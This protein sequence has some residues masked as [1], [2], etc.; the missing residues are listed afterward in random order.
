MKE[1]HR[2]R[3]AIYGAASFLV[4]AWVAVRYCGMTPPW[5]TPPPQPAASLAEIPVTRIASAA[6]FHITEPHG[7]FRFNVTLT[8]IPAPPQ[9]W[10]NP[11]WRALLRV[12]SSGRFP[13]RVWRLRNGRLELIQTERVRAVGA[14]NHAFSVGTQFQP[15]D[16][17]AVEYVPALVFESSWPVQS[18]I[19]NRSGDP[20]SI[21]PHHGRVTP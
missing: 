11:D 1:R 20:T 2:L 7:P 14:I 6:I 17:I 10:N 3:L 15:G 16:S 5:R 4:V 8:T 9:V 13:V 21:E 19:D 12:D 18:V